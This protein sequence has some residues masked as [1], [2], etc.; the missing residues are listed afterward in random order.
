MTER[1]SVDLSKE[2][3]SS[4]RDN[5]LTI[6]ENLKS[7]SVTLMAATKT[8]PA[9]WINYAT[10]EC[11]LTD[12]GE[13]R[14]QELLAKYDELTLTGVNLHFIGRLQVNKVKYLIGKVCLIH[15]LDSLKLAEEISRR[16]EAKGLV[17]DVLYEVNIGEE[18][19][20]G[21][22]PEREVR[23]FLSAVSSL[24]GIRV[25]SLMVIGP[26]CPDVDGYRP[27]FARTRTL[28]DSLAEE[29]F[30][31]DKPILSMGMSDNY[32]LAASYGSTLVRPGT[33][34]FGARA[35]PNKE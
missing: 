16:S 23:A 5:L 9:S 30:F 29:G 25:R 22:I 7:H 24:R 34:V 4:I 2:I 18:E 12:I 19:A 3:K 31:G 14:V 27:F 20:K 11:G 35:Y 26:Y 8:V 32:A 33:A 17:T 28:F 6:R 13:N 10:Q 15:S 21:G 1:S